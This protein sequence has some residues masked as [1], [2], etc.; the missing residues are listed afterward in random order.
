MNILKWLL[1]FLQ[2]KRINK[3][4]ANYL[5]KLEEQ[6]ERME[7][8]NNPGSSI[9]NYFHKINS[10]PKYTK[11]VNEYMDLTSQISAHNQSIEEI[12][13]VVETFNFDNFIENPMPFDKNYFNRYDE[14]I[15]SIESFPK[16][17]ERYIEFVISIKELSDWIEI[18]KEQ[19]CLKHEVKKTYVSFF[20]TDSYL[21]GRRKKDIVDILN[22]CS[23]KLGQYPKTYYIIDEIANIDEK[24][25]NHNDDYI[26]RH[27]NDPIFDD[28]TGKR[29]GADQKRAILCDSISNL[30]V[31]GAGSGKTLT[32]CGKAKYLLEEKKIP[33]D[34]MFFLSYSN[35]ST[36]DLEK[37]L[38]GVTVGL[39]VST[40]H[41]LGLRILQ[42]A[43][44]IKRNI[45][46]NYDAIIE[47]YFREEIFKP[48]N[49]G[50]LKKSIRILC[51]V[52]I[53]QIFL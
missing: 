12:N 15:K 19:Y 31:A 11:I 53:R 42:A 47:R 25:N 8:I 50:T 48:Q 9:E 33:K 3:N 36:A 37:K 4:F 7:I 44:G 13:N 6:F 30:V 20:E 1:N 32:I 16:K 41:S 35:F 18:I 28:V 5:N 45:D 10:N 14:V 52:F 2:H 34:E 38:E 23:Q 43:D 46:S 21:D 39:N 49:E 29:L 26:S 51:Q 17:N 24:I 22:Y 40:F 27:L